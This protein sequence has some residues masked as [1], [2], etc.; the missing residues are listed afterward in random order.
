M[1]ATLLRLE[2]CGFCVGM[3]ALCRAC[4]RGQVYCDDSCRAP[5]RTAQKLFLGGPK[6]ASE[7]HLKIGQS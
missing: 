3:F 4:F 7:G 2:R 1:D 6:T 5:A